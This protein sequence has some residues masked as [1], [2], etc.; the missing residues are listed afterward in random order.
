MPKNRSSRLGFALFV[1]VALFVIGRNV[2]RRYQEAALLD[3]IYGKD[4]EA[5]VALLARGV[6]ADN[7]ARLSEVCDQAI[8]HNEPM[9]AR[10]LLQRGIFPAHSDSQ[11]VL[12]TA[13]GQCPE[14]VPLLL[15]KGVDVNAQSGNGDTALSS[16]VRSRHL[17]L[18]RLLLEHGA[19]ANIPF[20][21]NIQS[22]VT[23]RV[24]GVVSLSTAAA[25]GDI[26]MLTLLLAH[27]AHISAE[28]VRYGPL[29]AAVSHNSP[30]ALRFLLEHGAGQEAK[31]NAL[32][33]AVEQ[34]RLDAIRL[35]LQYGAHPGMQS[36]AWLT[37]LGQ[38]HSQ[39]DAA[40]LALLRPL[41]I[42][43]TPDDAEREA[44]NEEG[45]TPLLAALAKN[46]VQAAQ[47]WIAQGA[48]VNARD[49]NASVRE[50][51]GRTPLLE[52]EDHCPD[53][54]TLLLTKHADPNGMTPLGDTPLKKAVVAGN[55]AVVQQLLAHGANPNLHQPQQHSPLYFARKRGRTAIAALLE[56]AGGK[57][58]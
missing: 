31:N 52:A 26:P 55:T 15:E 19:D 17:A 30:E 6:F 50:N 40:L 24:D 35:L 57:E 56:Q 14:V 58:E 51:T 27:G 29:A 45:Q 3:A 37:A 11:P 9:V 43:A 1:L 8:Q 2:Y 21:L 49:T 5:A 18:A 47:Y 48:N 42:T 25:N 33:C 34:K 54:V 20:Q 44:R 28:P 22:N 39:G 36:A 41:G 7:S 23:P 13:A 12:I 46:Q 4:Q 53:M 10:T 38:V 16:C 32:I